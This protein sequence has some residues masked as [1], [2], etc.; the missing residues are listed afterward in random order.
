MEKVPQCRDQMF[1]GRTTVYICIVKYFTFISPGRFDPV[2]TA[3]KTQSAAEYL[4]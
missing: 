2:E 3:S 1:N 4:M